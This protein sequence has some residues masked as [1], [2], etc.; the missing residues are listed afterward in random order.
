MS[1][2]GGGDVDTTAAM[3]GAV[4][5]ARV[6]YSNIPQQLSSKLHDQ[7]AYTTEDL[8]KIAS[9]AYDVMLTGIQ[10]QTCCQW[11]FLQPFTRE[12][13]IFVVNGT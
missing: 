5:G 3:A 2:Q 7:S 13:N 4:V 6:G 12:D 8:V 10:Y 11:K 9:T 1:F